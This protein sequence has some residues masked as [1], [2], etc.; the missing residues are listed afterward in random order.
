MHCKNIIFG[1]F[2]FEKKIFFTY[3]KKVTGVHTKPKIPGPGIELEIPI[4]SFL[5]GMADLY[6]KSYTQ[7]V[8]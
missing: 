8:F 5:Y 2:R 6:A 3:N 4:H 7:I 1:T